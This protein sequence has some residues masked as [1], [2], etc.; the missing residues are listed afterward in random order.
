MAQ[1]EKFDIVLHGAT[2]FTGRLVAQHLAKVAGDR[3]ITFALSGRSVERLEAVRAALPSEKVIPLIVADA[4]DSDTIRTMVAQ[5]HAVVA[6]A[7]P[8]Q[9][10]GEPVVAACSAL[11]V[12][13]LDLSGEVAWMRA[14]IDRYDA[15]ARASGARI[16]FSSGF[17]SIPLELGVMFLQAEARQ[18][19]GVT[20]ERVLAR[21]T[22]L[23]GGYSGGTLASLT[24][25][26]AADDPVV[27]ALLANPFALTPGFSGPTQPGE[28]DSV[29][30]DDILQQWTAPF[31]MAPINTR[32][33]HRCNFLQG[34]PYGTDFR[35][36]ERIATGP[37]EQGRE[38][39]ERL[40]EM[41]TKAARTDAPKSGEGPSEAEREAGF[42]DILFLGLVDRQ[43]SLAIKVHGDRDP[44]YGSTSKI[45]AE[46]AIYL[47][48][49][50]GDVAGGIWTPGAALGLPL[51]G[52][53]G[54]HAGLSFANA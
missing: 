5:T 44:G 52:W 36:D 14:M 51:A 23:Q 29:T 22:A 37:G 6:T 50:G 34:H 26:A 24:M 4:G 10:Y 30:F 42:Y 20:V 7:G 17:D 46:T 27:A 2:G 54:D 53:L 16:L 39:A 32:N 31:M 13:Y 15:E 25:A 3:G 9:L 21:I 43:G 11:G 33:V 48:K 18:R 12:D 35:Y 19:F 1:Q 45:I 8:F 28:E 49:F 47:R 40:S 38:L 41:L